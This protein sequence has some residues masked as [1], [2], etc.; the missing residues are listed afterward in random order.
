MNNFRDLQVWQKAVN[1]VTHVYQLTE[2]VPKTEQYGLTNKIRRSV[3]SISSNIAEGAGR[4]S[5]KGFKQFLYISTGS[6]YELETQLTI[7]QNLNLVDESEYEAV[8]R[9]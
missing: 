6:C 7:S 2:N 3:I 9:N 4:K 5:K 8:K 1:L